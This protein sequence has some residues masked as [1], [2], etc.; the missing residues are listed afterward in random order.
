MTPWWNDVSDEHV[1]GMF[2]GWRIHQQSAAGV[3]TYTTLLLGESDKLWGIKD[4]GRDKS[5]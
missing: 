3:N 2:W 1:E 4:I 5:P